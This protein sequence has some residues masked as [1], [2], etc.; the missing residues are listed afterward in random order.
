VGPREEDV[1]AQHGRD[2]DG[3]PETDAASADGTGPPGTDEGIGAIDTSGQS[4]V[5]ASALPED[6]I[7]DAATGTAAPVAVDD[8][9]HA[10]TRRHLRGSSLFLFGRGLSLAANLVVQVLIVRYLPVDAYGAFTYVLSLVALGETLVTLGVDRAISRFLPIYQEHEDWPK[11]FGT[12]VFVFTTILSLGLALIVLVQGLGGLFLDK[13]VDDSLTQTLLLILVILAPL[14][15]MD[16][17]LANVFAV[18]AKPQAIFFR[19]YLL[20]PVMRLTVVGL[21]AAGALGVTFLAVGYVVTGLVG[22]LTYLIVLGNVLRTEGLLRHFDRRALQFPVR[23]LLAYTLPLLSIDLVYL[24]MNTLDTVFVGYF[25]D[26]DAVAQLRVVQPVAGL[27]QL[28]YTSFALLFT[29]ALARLFARGDRAGAHELYWQTAVWMAVLSFPVFALTFSFSLP[30]TVTLYQDRYASS[31]L[32]LSFLALGRYVDTALGFNGLTL[33]V[34]GDMRW[35]VGVNLFAVAANLVLLVVLVPPFGAFGAAASTCL[36]LIAYNAA[37]Q[38]ALRRVAGIPGFERRHLAIYAVIVIVPLV[39]LAIEL[40]VRPGLLLAVVLAGVGS[41]VVLA[42]GRAHMRVA[43]TFPEL[44]R[45]P[46]VAR[47]VR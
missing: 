7:P 33:R 21:M 14:Q 20:F 35:L 22:V 29:P 45:I 42:I 13:A 17:V 12:L 8:R 11:L 9:A 6:V 1:L 31:A 25:R 43:E 4:V 39:L 37:K 36:A 18:F 47:L 27:N 44:L 24:V 41:L 34:F 28:V 38:V 15:A 26:V 16:T 32:V 10:A 3:R 2:A 46:I 19:K 5:D 30:V 23:E 40:V